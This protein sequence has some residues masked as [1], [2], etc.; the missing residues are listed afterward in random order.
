MRSMMTLLAASR[1]K[2]SVEEIIK[3]SRVD[4]IILRRLTMRPKDCFANRASRDLAHCLPAIGA[5]YPSGK[6]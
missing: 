5:L 6:R 2:P 1:A 3:A 4:A